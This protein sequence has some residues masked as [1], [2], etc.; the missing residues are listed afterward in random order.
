[1]KRMIRRFLFTSII[2]LAAVILSVIL[3]KDNRLYLQPLRKGCPGNSLMHVGM[4]SFSKEYVNLPAYFIPNR[5]RLNES[6]KF[7]LTG[8]GFANFFTQKGI[9]FCLSR[10]SLVE[11][12]P[13]IGSRKC[14]CRKSSNEMI[15]L[16]F[17]DYNP[18]TKIVPLDE[19]EH[20]VSFITGN[21]PTKWYTDISTYGAILYKDVRKGIDIKFYGS[22][23]K[24]LEYDII[25]KPGTAPE[26]LRFSYRGIK[27]LRLTDEGDMEVV[28]SHGVIIQHKPRFYQEINRKRVAIKGGFN[29][30]DSENVTVGGGKMK[31]NEKA[32][33]YGF[34]V[35]SYDRGH[36]LI[37]DP[38]ITYS[39]YIGGTNEDGALSIGLDQSGNVY[40]AGYTSSIDFP[41]TSPLQTSNGGQIDAFVTKLNATGTARVYS[42]YIGGEGDDVAWGIAIDGSGNAY[43]AGE[44]SS[45]NLPV[46][47]PIQ[48]QNAGQ[49]DAFILK[50]NPSGSALVYSSYI[51]G[52]GDDVARGIAIDGSGNAYVA[53]ETSSTNLPVVSPIQTQNAGQKD[54]FILKINPS[55]NALVYSTFLGGTGDDTAYGI[56]VDGSGRAYIAGA[57]NSVDFP[58]VS[59]IQA[60]N[61]GQLDAFVSKIASSGSSVIYS[62]YLGGTLNDTANGIAVDAS[63][64]TYIAGETQSHDFPTFNPFQAQNNTN[65]YYI[66]LGPLDGFV[67]K[68]N[69][70]GSEFVYSTYIGGAQ[71]DYANAITIDVAGN[72]YITGGTYSDNFPMVKPIYGIF[73]GGC[74]GLHDAFVTKLDGSGSSLVYSTYIGG[75]GNDDGNAIAVDNSG[76]AYVAGETQSTDFPLVN[77]IQ[78]TMESDQSHAFVLKMDG[79]LVDLTPPIIT[80]TDPTDR[81]SSCMNYISVTFSEEMDSSSINTDTFYVKRVTGTITYN[82]GTAKFTSTSDLIE[83]ATYVATITTAVKDLAG[84]H[85][86]K[87]YT[88]SFSHTSC[89]IV[90]RSPSLDMGKSGGGCFISSVAY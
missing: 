84:N 62:T 33:T 19:T 65:S 28:L 79:S 56:A 73:R 20:K 75:G 31:T 54:G 80:K 7:S 8:N 64:N 39:T 63:G 70:L 37:I 46:V 40:I 24:N 43:V 36:P 25:I 41:T 45:T 74:C 6:I 49:K 32:F 53:G 69:T 72:A 51:G 4:T 83:G 90:P 11:R 38:I 82:N 21:N 44:T 47:S 52:E 15:Q 22:D 89:W 57:T 85:M 55:G 9:Y 5:G 14:N 42:T 26:G 67:T 23:N 17:E 16:V 81:G 34:M 12:H 61:N 10:K 86:T 88:W 30:Q 68:I 18:D 59:P 87:D 2:C 48:T 50:I 27:D 76:N 66:N 29:I 60:S 71:V 35:S 3:I 58:M 1:M 78:G 77:P 13:H